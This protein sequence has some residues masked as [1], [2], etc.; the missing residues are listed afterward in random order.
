MSPRRA[1]RYV[2]TFNRVAAAHGRPIRAIALPVTVR[3]EGDPTPG[4]AMN[5]PIASGSRDSL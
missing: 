3:Y 2:A 4:Q 5:I 1:A